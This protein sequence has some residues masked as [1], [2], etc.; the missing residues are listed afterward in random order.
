MFHKYKFASEN[1][2]ECVLW[3]YKTHAFILKSIH[4]IHIR[5]LNRWFA[6]AFPISRVL[7]N[8]Q[9]IILT[10]NIRKSR[11]RRVC[12]IWSVTI[13]TPYTSNGQARMNG[14]HMHFRIIYYY[15]L[16]FSCLLPFYFNQRKI[17]SVK[18]LR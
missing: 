18:I 11:H 2:S 12:L 1:K 5:L 10:R 4:N 14:I 17:N 6:E 9:H 13:L 7:M 8:W 16:V 3:V 15:L